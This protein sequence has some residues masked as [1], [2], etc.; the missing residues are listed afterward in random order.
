[1]SQIFLYKTQAQRMEKKNF[2]RMAEMLGMA[3]KVVETEEGLAAHDGTRALVYGQP[4][5]TM[6]GVL[7]YTDQEKSL[8]EIPEKTP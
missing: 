6:A 7:F 2:S 8:G 1:M 5:A 4:C 3:K